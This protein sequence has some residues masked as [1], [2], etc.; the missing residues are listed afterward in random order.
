[1]IVASAIVW[2]ACGGT[3]PAAQTHRASNP[4]ASCES[5]RE[6]RPDTQCISLRLL[7][8]RVESGAN[9]GKITG[10]VMAVSSCDSAVALLASPIDTRAS[11]SDAWEGALGSVYARLSVYD[12]RVAT[13]G[14]E[15][16]GV[17]VHALPEFL[18]VPAR[19]SVNFRLEGESARLAGIAEGKRRFVELCTFATPVKGPVP[20]SA[21]A[22]DVGKSIEVHER[23]AGRE[24]AVTLRRSAV[25]VCTPSFSIGVSNATASQSRAQR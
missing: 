12:R 17:V 19:S 9:S 23:G 20:P 25:F 2:V 8:A 14:L 24:C 7:D 16:R 3:E 10:T 18:I 21:A 22:F 11:A 5:T 4:I 1:M 6:E 13:G 15:D